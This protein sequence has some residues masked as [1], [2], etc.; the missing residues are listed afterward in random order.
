MKEKT[1]KLILSIVLIAF[2]GYMAAQSPKYKSYVPEEKMVNI[3]GI[4]VPELT[5]DRIVFKLP[6]A[7][8]RDIKNSILASDISKIYGKQD[9]AAYYAG[10]ER[11]IRN[12]TLDPKSFTYEDRQR[13]G[14]CDKRFSILDNIS[15]RFTD[16]FILEFINGI[17]M[18]CLALE[19]ENNAG[20]PFYPEYIDEALIQYSYIFI[21]FPNGQLHHYGRN[22]KS[23]RLGSN[24][25]IDFWS[26][27][28]GSEY[29]YADSGELLFS[30]DHEQGFEMDFSTLLTNVLKSRIEIIKKYN[31]DRNV[32]VP[33]IKRNRNELGKF[34]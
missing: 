27:P 17:K 33:E 8:K 11:L 6:M 23:V 14:K 9:S 15:Y 19:G 18:Q 24:I 31:I 32:R 2:S 10:K 29:D 34:G 25:F 1:V 30:I 12:K 7:L 5:D 22:I 26:M 28:I 21:Y 13:R 4:N 16:S 3:K 20:S